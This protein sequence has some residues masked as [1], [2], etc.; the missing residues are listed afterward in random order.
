MTKNIKASATYNYIFDQFGV[1]LS[2][3]DA[4]KILK[5]SRD[6][7]DRMVHSGEMPAAK[8]G[9]RYIISTEDLVEWF[10]RNVTQTQ[11]GILR[12]TA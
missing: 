3:N 11:H 7:L 8:I 6:V 1:F 2:I 12:Q 4:C 10:E 5:I 9:G